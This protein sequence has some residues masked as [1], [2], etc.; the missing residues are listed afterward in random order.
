MYSTHEKTE[1]LGKIDQ[2]YSALNEAVAGFS[3][4]QANFKP[5]SGGW[6]VAGVVEH[7]ARVQERVIGR[8]DQLLVSPADM[9]GSPAGKIEDE[10]LRGK[11]VDRSRKAQ[12]PEPT[13]PTGTSMRDSLERL[14]AGPGQIAKI[15]ETAPADF[16][17][18]SVAHP[19]FGPLDCHQWL[20]LLGSHCSRHTQ[21]IVEVKSSADFPRG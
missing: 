14:V 9:A 19:F 15:L 13:H 20:I 4:A 21:Q 6:S 2:A 1:V 7:L 5:A 3:E 17:Q 16:R 10:T 12:A 18:R 11:L 8:I